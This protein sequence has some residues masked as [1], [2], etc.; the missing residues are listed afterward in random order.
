MVKGLIKLNYYLIKIQVGKFKYKLRTPR[1]KEI[2]A[3]VVDISMKKQA[4]VIDIHSP[5]FI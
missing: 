5:I 1:N 4:K 3:F 2:I